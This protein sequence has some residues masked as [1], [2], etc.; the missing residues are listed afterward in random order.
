M[1][2]HC[3]TYVGS[4]VGDHYIL[5]NIWLVTGTPSDSWFVVHWCMKLLTDTDHTYSSTTNHNRQC[6]TGVSRQ[7][8]GSKS[9]MRTSSC[10]AGSKLYKGRNY[11]IILLNTQLNST[12]VLVHILK[13]RIVT[14]IHRQDNETVP[15]IGHSTCYTE[16]PVYRLHNVL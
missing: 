15:S 11:I 4:L 16:S 10:S 5:S 9:C 12:S 14:T 7:S 2:T 3:S 13:R 8:S 6:S 1:T